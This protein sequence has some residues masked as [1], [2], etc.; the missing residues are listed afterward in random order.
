MD[1]RSNEKRRKGS[2]S[3]L[4]R[5]QQISNN[6]HCLLDEMPQH[7]FENSHFFSEES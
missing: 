3:W 2:Y 7:D 4:P 1:T 6:G 5:I